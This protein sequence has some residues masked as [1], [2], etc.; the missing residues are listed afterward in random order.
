LFLISCSEN[1]G[2]GALSKSWLAMN[3]PPEQPTCLPT[4]G[5]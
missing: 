2:D 3:F 5:S 1:S 4:I